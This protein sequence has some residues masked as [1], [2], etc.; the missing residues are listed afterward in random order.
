MIVF[1]CSFSHLSPQTHIMELMKVPDQS[2]LADFFFFYFN[3]RNLYILHSCEHIQIIGCHISFRVCSIPYFFL[4][5]IKPV[6]LEY[7]WTNATRVTPECILILKTYILEKVLRAFN[8]RETDHVQR[9]RIQNGIQLLNAH[10][11]S[12]NKIN[13]SLRSEGN[14]FRAGVL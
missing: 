8:R 14:Y 11:E 4:V 1:F 2:L 7:K 10:I 13:R 9:I 5:L 6:I 3:I 12:S